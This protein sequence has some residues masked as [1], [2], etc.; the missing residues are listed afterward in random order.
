MLI[1]ASLMLNRLRN[2]ILL[3]LAPVLLYSCSGYEKALKSK[4]VNYKL[5]KANYYYDKKQYQH[6]NQLYEGLIPVMKNTRNYEPLYYHYCYSFYYMK[7]YLSASYHFRNFVDFFPSSK[8]AEECEFMY[9]LCL[10]KE[11]PKASLDPT[12]TEKALE[13][14]QSY[15]NTHPNSKHLEEAS[16]YVDQLRAKLEIK[17]ADAAKLYYNIGQFKAACIA[18]KSVMRNYPESANSDMYQFMVMK[19][20]YKY[21]QGSTR[22]KQEE[23]F[24]SALNAYQELKEGYPQSKFMA[25]AEKYRT[26][27]DLSVKKLRNEHK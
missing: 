8:D 22:E 1:F 17:E 4:D 15:I 13:A 2:Y 24:A 12:N 21:A 7:D 23:R 14:L 5:S 9:G 18:Y 6:A 27:A 19:S 16:H 3:L 20:W 10:F 25:E 11:S 26:L